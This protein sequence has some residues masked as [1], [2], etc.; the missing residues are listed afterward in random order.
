MGRR[1]S[2]LKLNSINFCN[3]GM[4]HAIRR[5]IIVP[6]FET[7]VKRRNNFA[8]WRELEKTQ[9]LGRDEIDRRQL[10]A[11]KKLIQHAYD[12]C[13]YYRETWDGMGLRPG[14]L[15]SLRD[16]SRWPVVERADILGNRMQMR[17]P[18]YANQLISKST[19]GSSGEPLHFDYNFDSE[20][21]R[22]AATY[23]GYNWAGAPPGARQLYIW[24]VPLG[25]QPKW[26]RMKDQWY[27]AMY[28][29]YILNSFGL[30]EATVGKFADRISNHKPDVI[31]AYTNPLY[32]LA[33]ML[34]ESG[35]RV[36]PPRS[37]VVGAEKLHPFQRILIERVFQAPVFETYGSRE[38]MLM[39]AECDRHEGLHL[40]QE[41]LLLE[42]VN[43]DGSP[44]PDGQEGE[45]VITDLFNFGMPFVRYKNGDRAIAGLKQCSCGRGLPMLRSVLGRTLDVIRTPDGRR[46]PGEFFPH[47]L[48]D[49]KAI[50][51]FQ[52]VQIA[53]D[54]V[55]IRVVCGSGWTDADKKRVEAATREALGPE[56]NLDVK[57]VEEI[58]L[59]NRGKLRVVVSLCGD[60]HR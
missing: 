52:V 16:F 2:V 58:A 56:V 47:M 35:R 12:H 51:R 31:V 18:A 57:R 9:W 43:E 30:S 5:N 24:G 8:Y 54:L 25:H 10:D 41:Q 40:T 55:E 59:T 27:H 13:P 48:K 42:V 45:L 49:F 20:A 19:G 21:R 4:S 15:Q 38:F 26:R 53:A 28:G 11:L 22:M 23:R 1:S 14:N 37:I 36:R 46:I 39:G 50:K 3:S 7:V 29:R 17:A 44:T 33:R 32:E 6:L 60:E 34:E